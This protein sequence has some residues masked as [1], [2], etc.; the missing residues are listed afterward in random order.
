MAVSVTVRQ[1]RQAIYSK[2]GVDD[3]AQGHPS[4]LLL[5]RLFHEI[6]ADL[7]GS[8]RSLNW[9]EALSGLDPEKE[10]WQQK[11]VDHAYDRLIGPRLTRE[12][13]RLQDSAEQVLH[14]WT[15]CKAMCG[16][17]VGI[18]WT[19]KQGGL[20][21]EDLAPVD[22]AR[23][24]LLT[25]EVSLAW[26]IRKNGWT[27]EV[28]VTGVA[29][30]LLRIP[31][32]GQWCVIELKLGR[33]APQA[34][35]MQACL[36]HQMLSA[37]AR[38]EVTP[39]AIA[40]VSFHP[41]KKEHLVSPEQIERVKDRL[42]NLIGECASVLPTQAEKVAVPAQGALDSEEERRKA[43]S[44]ASRKHIELGQKLVKV[45]NEYGVRADL[46]GDP[47]AG[48]TFLR[49]PVELG[50][51]VHVKAAQ[52]QAPNIQMR[53]QLDAEPFIHLADGCV[54]IDIQ[55]PDRQTVKFS[56]IEGQLPPSDPLIGCSK[57]PVGVDLN[58]RLRFADLAEP[59]IIH[60]LVAG[61]AGSGK[62]EWLRSALAGLLLTNGPD[63]LK[64]VLIDP[65]RNAFNELKNSPFLFD[66][67]SLVYPD[68]CPAAGVL[69]RLADEMDARYKLMSEINAGCLKEYVRKTGKAVPRIV[70]FCDEYAD[71]VS[72]PKKERK[73]VEGQ[74]G[75]LGAK[76]RAAGIHLIIA[77]QHPSREII[78]GALQTNIPA[79]V[80]LKTAKAIESRMLLNVNGAEKLLGKGDLL[81]KDIGDPVRLQSPYLSEED[82]K[83][84]FAA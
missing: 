26:E 7:A 28:D 77:T 63:T 23:E 39:G 49:Y 32:N 68:E 31:E 55:R 83:R 74:I 54:V 24:L 47:I 65:K 80:G 43:A 19:A 62:S 11:L 42:V 66:E 50:H 51:G 2:T 72:G 1:V 37:A 64:L 52:R 41:E 60:I 18:L 6:V 9:Q 20:L 82:R 29:D 46:A 61:S 58:S 69:A 53:L 44:T 76:A 59:E 67:K 35:L 14:F 73:E 70:C 13:V 84:I 8:D 81:F 34:D 22:S 33:G 12:R 30:L 10:I 71:L 16:W 25:P 79:R 5:G 15:A 36:Y 56:E 40:L 78:K 3:A 4:T 75:R 57:V 21:N 48:P 27:D 17:L 45:F 38:G